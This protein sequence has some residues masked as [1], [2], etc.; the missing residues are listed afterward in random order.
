MK[1]IIVLLLL[2]T[3]LSQAAFSEIKFRGELLGSIA[4]RGIFDYEDEN[5]DP[6]GAITGEPKAGMKGD[7]GYFDQP[8]LYS[9]FAPYNVR[10]RFRGDINN[11]TNTF[12]GFFRIT[13]LP[14]YFIAQHDLRWIENQESP[15]GNIWWK[16]IPQIK[17]T[18]G[19]FSGAQGDMDARIFLA[20]EGVFH[21]GYFGRHNPDRY[22]TW[23]TRLVHA[24]GW[25][26]EAAGV[27][28]EIINPFDLNGLYIIATLP[29]LQHYRLFGLGETRKDGIF[30]LFNTPLEDHRKVPAQDI[31]AQTAVRVAY[32]IRGVGQIVLSWDGGTGTLSGVSPSSDRIYSFD[33]SYINAGFNLTAIRNTQISL[34]FE[35]PLP[36]TDYRRG[37]DPIRG[38]V[39]STPEQIHKT[40]GDFT[41][42]LPYSVDVRASY[43]AGDFQFGSGFTAYFGGY[44]EA[45]WATVT[46]EGGRINDPFEFGVTINPV[47]MG[48]SFMNIGIVGEFRFVE[49][50]NSNI[51]THPFALIGMHAD[52][53]PWMSFN[54]NP[55]ISTKIMGN[56]SAWIGFQ[57]RGQHY[58]GFKGDDGKSWKMLYMWAV[59]MG[60][61]YN[62]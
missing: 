47:Y 7:E 45:G 60:L 42:Q 48:L 10:V 13:L 11:D 14:D 4:V 41:R 5:G 37:L 34:G 12:G 8:W 46:R 19:N 52:R 43:T 44:L 26:E 28:L 16:P 56:A 6:K 27:T 20:N 40:H 21:F 50:Y 53:G 23:T 29:L 36:V 58:S 62:Y 61:V 17:V 54:V 15:L 57:L 30:D 25:E 33:V 32:N 2:F 49:Y 1:K 31:F 24:W 59:P 22:G 3:F 55:Y 39:T 9:Y 18:F 51:L 35:L 38:N